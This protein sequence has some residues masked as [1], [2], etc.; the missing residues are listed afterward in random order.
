MSVL[1][2]NEKE[3][4]FFSDFLLHV[5]KRGLILVDQEMSNR[6]KMLDRDLPHIKCYDQDRNGVIHYLS[7][8]RF[9]HIYEN[10]E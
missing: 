6:Q 4:L 2:I 3:T 10:S 8:W 5:A 7:S 9:I 1:H